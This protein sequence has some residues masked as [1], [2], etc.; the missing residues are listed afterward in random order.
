[1]LLFFWIH[2]RFIIL[3]TNKNAWEYAAQSILEFFNQEKIDEMEELSISKL[4][5]QAAKIRKQELDST[6]KNYTHN[7]GNCMLCCTHKNK[8]N[9]NIFIPGI[10]HA[11]LCYTMPLVIPSGLKASDPVASIFNSQ[12][13]VYKDNK[14]FRKSCDL[15]MMHLIY[16]YQQKEHLKL[17]NEL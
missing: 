13:K 10:I 4:K 9:R 14:E 1:M 5:R 3:L 17:I 2:I 8:L 6:T 12:E 16:E 7:S 11:D 15:K